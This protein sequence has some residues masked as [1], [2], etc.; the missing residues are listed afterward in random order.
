MAVERARR[1][2]RNRRQHHR[3][4]LEKGVQYYRNQRLHTASVAN[5][6]E[7]GLCLQGSTGSLMVGDVLKLFVTLPPQGVR[8]RDRLCLLQ[9]Q[10]VWTRNNRAGV[11]FIDPPLENTL[12]LRTYVKLAA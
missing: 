7:G 3:A 1:A 12:E 8:R 4:R 5:I 11:R 2:S 6:S 10:V 9:G